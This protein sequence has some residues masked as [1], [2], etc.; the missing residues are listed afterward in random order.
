MSIRQG[1]Q[2]QIQHKINHIITADLDDVGDR[3]TAGI[4]PSSI[5]ATIHDV[6]HPCMNFPILRLGLFCFDSRNAC[7]TSEFFTH[8]LVPAPA[9]PIHFTILITL[10]LSLAHHGRKKK[11]Q[12]LNPWGRKQV[13]VRCA[14]QFVVFHNTDTHV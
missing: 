11:K 5:I 7:P 14:F 8:M 2:A 12:Y 9:I 4:N 3:E 10:P 6:V 13:Y 1:T